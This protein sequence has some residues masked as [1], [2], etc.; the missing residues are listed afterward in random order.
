M[1]QRLHALLAPALAERLT[2]VLNHV[3]SPSAWPPSGCSR[4]PAARW[5]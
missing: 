5:R 1:L 2:L 4:M 3:L